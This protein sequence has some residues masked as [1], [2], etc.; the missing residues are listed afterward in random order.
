MFRTAPNITSPTLAR[1]GDLPSPIRW[2]ML[3]WPR[4][5]ARGRRRSILQLLFVSSIVCRSPPTRPTT[6]RRRKGR[7]SITPSRSTMRAGSSI[8]SSSGAAALHPSMRELARAATDSR[9]RLTPLRLTLLGA[10]LR[11][12]K[13]C[14]CFWEVGKTGT[15][16]SWTVASGI[17][18]S[19]SSP[20]WGGS[21][22]PGGCHSARAGLARRRRRPRSRGRTGEQVMRWA[23]GARRDCSGTN[24]ASG[25]HS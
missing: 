10:C 2:V 25:L 1:E 12:Y 8:T 20:A 11:Y 14:I 21:R 6:S 5:S 7:T 23:L 18:S 17:C 13:L 16:S 9:T 24:H 22:P 4:R 15:C 3:S 19:S